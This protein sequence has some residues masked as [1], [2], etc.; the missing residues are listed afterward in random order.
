M[1]T[2]DQGS[3]LC[4]RHMPAWTIAQCISRLGQNKCRHIFEVLVEFL[5]FVLGKD[6]AKHLN[7]QAKGS[8]LWL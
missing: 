1:V 3:A 8:I 2:R 6:W 5:D 7:G 4:C